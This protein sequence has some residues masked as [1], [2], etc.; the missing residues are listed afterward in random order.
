M[1]LMDFK[2]DI[3]RAIF[4]TTRSRKKKGCPSLEK[5]EPVIKRRARAGCSDDL[6]MDGSG[7][8]S[9]KRDLANAC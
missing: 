3:C 1:H 2:L 9:E 6:T 5:N 4:E 7:H 8:F